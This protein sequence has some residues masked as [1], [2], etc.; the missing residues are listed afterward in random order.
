MFPAA[1][2]AGLLRPAVRSARQPKQRPGNQ[3]RKGSSVACSAPCIGGSLHSGRVPLR[4]I[5]NAHYLVS[6]D[7]DAIFLSSPSSFD[8]AKREPTAPD[9]T[10]MWPLSGPDAPRRGSRLA[11]TQR[12]RGSRRPVRHL[13][14]VVF[15]NT[16]RVASIE[17]TRVLRSLLA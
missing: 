12:E 11:A 16:V 7:S 4:R 1:A 10:C 9:Q 17:L 3:V 13:Q 5:R 14:V 6:G 8:D 15:R 2:G